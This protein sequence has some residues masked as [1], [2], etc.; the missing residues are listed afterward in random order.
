MKML[1]CGE[2]IDTER[3]INV[4]NPF[5]QEIIDTVP[6]ATVQHVRQAV[7]AAADYDFSLTAWERYEILHSFCALLKKHE[8]QFIELIS[9]ES[10]KP[11]K[12]S[13]AEVNR[14]YQ[15]FLISAEEAKRING[16]I[17]PVDAVKGL[18]KRLAFILREPV[19]VVAAITP[20][21]YPLNLVAHKV[22]PAIAANNAVILKPSSLTPL[23]ALKMAE[24][25]LQAGLPPKMLH[26]IT[27]KSSEIGDE[28]VTNPLVRKITFTGSVPVG[29]A[30]CGKIGMKKVCMELGGN[31]PLI[32]LKDANIEEAVSCAVVGAFGNN[33]QRCTSI[34]R[35]IIE[36]SIAD[37]FIERFVERTAKLKVGNQM[38]PSTDIGPLITEKNAKEI[39]GKVSSAISNGAK[40]IYGGK[41]VDSLYWPSIL[42]FVSPKSR[43]VVEETFGP[44]AP[45]IRVKNFDEAIAVAN[46]TAYGLQCGIF[47]NDLK[48]AVEAARNIRAGAV[49]INDGPGFRAEHLPFGGVKD[50][51]IGR[52]GIKYAIEDMTQLKTIIL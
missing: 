36:E 31:D 46:S 11:I 24:L 38:D 15:T 21:N 18:P 9:K 33:G 22:G 19:G 43:I 7:A 52:E 37:Q 41:R 3:R 40:L 34:K 16:E 49:I 8:D 4:F 48:H 39:E 20:F 6:S 42:D 50:S 25:L 30:I 44:V 17:L 35:I 10:G 2:W 12:E 29:K 5:N 32:V 23:T 27:G 51:G 26:V 1:L 13:I 14:S 47:T 45:F 28:I